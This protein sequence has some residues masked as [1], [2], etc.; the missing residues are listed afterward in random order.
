[1]VQT[2]SQFADRFSRLMVLLARA[3]D[4]ETL[5]FESQRDPLKTIETAVDNLFDLI[6]LDRKR[7]GE[8]QPSQPTHN[9]DALGPRP[10]KILMQSKASSDVSMEEDVRLVNPISPKLIHDERKVRF[11]FADDEDS[12]ND[13]GETSHKRSK[14]KQMDEDFEKSDIAYAEKEYKSDNKDELAKKNSKL[15]IKIS[16]HADAFHTHK[17]ASHSE[18]S[19]PDSESIFRTLKRSTTLSRFDFDDVNDLSLN[20]EL[21][22]LGTTF[23]SSAITNKL[24]SVAHFERPVLDATS[25][26]T[27][28]PKSQHPL[29]LQRLDK[30]L[31]LMS[32]LPTWK[33]YTTPGYEPQAKSATSMIYL[34][35]FEEFMSCA[36]DFSKSLG[37]SHISKRYQ[38]VQRTD[39]DFFC[40]GVD[41]L[42]EL[43]HRMKLSI[44]TAEDKLHQVLPK[45]KGLSISLH[46]DSCKS[47]NDS[48]DNDTPPSPICRNCITELQNDAEVTNPKND[49]RATFAKVRPL[50]LA[51]YLLNSTNGNAEGATNQ[52][53]ADEPE[54]LIPLSITDL[55]KTSADGEVIEDMQAE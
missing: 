44:G 39:I 34:S 42:S 41:Q 52:A 30:L 31:A 4:G 23:S 25:A 33:I 21:L 28:H 6:H 55:Y 51:C 50:F 35:L 5:R 12:I 11:L 45:L 2:N 15:I 10:T 26:E 19:T 37:S 16:D 36:I 3:V 1:M 40:A 9:L 54:N 38:V 27:A 18:P 29:P 46:E 13:D 47:Q 8:Q 17:D 22:N 49:I 48:S 20:F 14:A 43:K 7:M 32:S 53:R 24:L